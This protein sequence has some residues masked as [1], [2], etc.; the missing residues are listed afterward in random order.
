MLS[1]PP[2]QSPR[3]STATPAPR[4]PPPL[5]ALVALSISQDPET[6]FPG[7]PGLNGDFY[8]ASQWNHSSTQWGQGAT[9]ITLG[10]AR[11][12]ALSK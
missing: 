7:M 10:E 5:Q 6:S 9:G 11:C 1:R 3:G 12:T 8:S 2:R 4:Y